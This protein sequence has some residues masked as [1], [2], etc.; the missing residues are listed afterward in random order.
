MKKQFLLITLLSLVSFISCARQKLTNGLSYAEFS[1]DYKFDDFLKKG[2][3]KTDKE[4]IDFLIENVIAREGV[5]DDDTSLFTGAGCSTIQ[6]GNNKDGFIF[7]R[8]FD[9]EDCNALILKTS[10]A[11]GYKSIST[12]NIDFIKQGAGRYSFLLTD[13]L[14]NKIAS[15]APLDGMNEK[16]LCVSVNMIEDYERVN[17]KDGSKGNLTT[18]TAVRLLLDKASSTREALSLLQEYNFNPSFGFCVHFAICDAQGNAVAVEYID[19]KMSV[20]ETPIL[21]NFYVTPG[22]KYGIGTRES[23]ERFNVLNKSIST[24][25]DIQKIGAVLESVSKHNYNE[26]EA[27]QW[28]VVFDQKNLT[29]TYFY[30]ENYKQSWT[31]SLR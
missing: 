12:V 13:S 26:F 27:T 19:N 16:G 30:R 29:A 22:N 24:K 9:W 28:S 23:H 3:A 15:Y 4:V 6:A 17:Q 18:T 21:T 10:P 2:G 25:A 8:N 5:L 14:I 1:G 7:G 11:S 31:Y 20:I